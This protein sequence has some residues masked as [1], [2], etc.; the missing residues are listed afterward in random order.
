MKL[1]L[2]QI[3]ASYF[4]KIEDITVKQGQKVYNKLWDIYLKGV[5]YEYFRGLPNDE[6]EKKID[7]LKK[8]YDKR[9]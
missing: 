4:K 9:I 7:L 6:I 3:R 1:S 5:L 8:A 2:R